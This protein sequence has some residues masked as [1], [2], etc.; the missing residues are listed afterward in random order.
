LEAVKQDLQAAQLQIAHLEQQL[1][2]RRGLSNDEKPVSTR[3]R[4]TLLVIIAAL[5]NK[6]AIE[7][8]SRGAAA[9]IATETQLLGA[10]IGEDSIRDLLKQ[11]PDALES[12]LPER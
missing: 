12:R 6:A 9:Q 7:V 3:Q 10:R 11:I 8:S 5:C 4:R 1:K 2:G